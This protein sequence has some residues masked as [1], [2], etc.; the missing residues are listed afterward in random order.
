VQVYPTLV[1][2]VA[3]GAVSSSVID[4]SLRRTLPF[5]FELGAM[6]PPEVAAR[7][8]YNRLDERNVSAPWMRALAA[9]A[10]E[11]SVVL[12]K[13]VAVAGD[14]SGSGGISRGGNGGGGGGVGSGMAL[15]ISPETL[16]GKT[17]CVVGPNANSTA[18][19]MGGYVNKHP[20]FVSTPYS[21]LQSRVGHVAKE[22]RL[23]MGCETTACPAITTNG[24]AGCDIA[25]LVL[26]L[27]NDAGSKDEPGDACGC[28]FGDAIEGEVRL[29][30][31]RNAGDLV[32][33][34]SAPS[35]L[36]TGACARVFACTTNGEA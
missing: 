35:V 36:T 10:A 31:M 22:V 27:T 3:S 5:R 32:C 6:D 34:C 23:V 17:V 18:A 15:P 24:L 13:N 20:P 7:N 29:P 21:A 1:A 8:P 9:R 11:R 28:P 33:A 26:G 14:I 2:S 19:Q 16:S 30:L 4:R 25:V 12:L